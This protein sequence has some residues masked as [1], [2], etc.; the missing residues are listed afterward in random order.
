ESVAPGLKAIPGLLEIGVSSAAG[1]P[2]VEF[3]GTS[4]AIASSAIVA[5]G[6]TGTLSLINGA[7]ETIALLTG[8]GGGSTALAGPSALTVG[9]VAL[10]PSA[11]MTANAGS[12]LT[13]LGNT[14]LNGASLQAAGG[15]ADLRGDLTLNGG[16]LLSEAAGRILLAGNLQAN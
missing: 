12:T 1:N 3:T 4:G 14:D 7:R 2:K 5:L 13:V 16:Q 8:T 9:D 10:G 6:P 11:T 15:F